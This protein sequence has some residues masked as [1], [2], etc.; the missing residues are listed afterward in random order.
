MPKSVGNVK[1]AEIVL[2]GAAVAACG[3]GGSVLSDLHFENRP[4]NKLHHNGYLHSTSLYPFCQDGANKYFIWTCIFSAETYYSI[5][6]LR[7]AS[8]ECRETSTG[9]FMKSL[10]SRNVIFLY[11][12]AGR[13]LGQTFDVEFIA[14]SV[15]I[16]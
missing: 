4:I 13:K 15:C 6:S 2:F 11:G 8:W 5:L 7:G 1:R 3:S 16:F 10:L 12:L 9:N 14:A